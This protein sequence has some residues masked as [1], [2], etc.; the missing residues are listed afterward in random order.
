M[1]L[2][3][4]VYGKSLKGIGNDYIKWYCGELA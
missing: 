3:R 2:L 1:L 4:H